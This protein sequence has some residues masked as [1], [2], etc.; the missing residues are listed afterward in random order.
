[1]DANLLQVQ[2][3]LNKQGASLTEDGVSGPATVAAIKQ[4]QLQNGLLP[5][6]RVSPEL[7][8]SLMPKDVVDNSPSIFSNVLTFMATNK[9]PIIILSSI[10]IFGG[11][12]WFLKDKLFSKRV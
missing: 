10:A 7:L 6:G 3:L 5:D 8:S 1:M 11:G 4:Y 9:K 2:Q 12:I